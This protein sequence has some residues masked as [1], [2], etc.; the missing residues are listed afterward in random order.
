MTPGQRKVI[1]L[2]NRNRGGKGKVSEP[3]RRLAEALGLRT[4]V[5]IPT[6]RPGPYPRHY[7]VDVGDPDL[8]VAVEV[9]GPSHRA[10]WVQAADRR[11]TYFLRSL[12]WSVSRCSNRD[13]LEHFDRTVR[14]ISC[15]I[16]R[17]S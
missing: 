5:V 3:E 9:D 13:V 7:T 12:G 10:L 17:S 2:L 4:H 15:V 1:R 8:M 6:G 16:A 14:R 11:K